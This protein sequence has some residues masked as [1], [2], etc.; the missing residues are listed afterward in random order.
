[1][2]MKKLLSSIACAIIILSC[3]SNDNDDS[4]TFLFNYDGVL[5]EEI[6]SDNNY[7]YRIIFNKSPKGITF[8]EIINQDQYSETLN[9]G[10]DYGFLYMSIIED[11]GDTLVL[12]VREDQDGD[13]VEY[14]Q[15]VNVNGNSLII[16]RSTEPGG[17]E[18]FIRLN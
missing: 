7:A 13:V 14:I 4:N 6:E 2:F 10:T 8:Q 15:T 18:N 5:W 11:N 16:S 1:M 3:S 12:N 9:F 17:D